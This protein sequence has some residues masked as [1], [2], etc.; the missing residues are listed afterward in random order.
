MF[1][2]RVAGARCTLLNTDEY[3]TMTRTWPI[4]MIRL[5]C[6]RCLPEHA[7]IYSPELVAD[8]NVSPSS[9]YRE[10]LPSVETVAG[11]KFLFC[12]Q[13]L[14]SWPQRPGAARQHALSGDSLRQ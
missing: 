3:V 11:S 12:C 2:K 6:A 4:R 1:E 8:M 9:P 13:P 14:P 5:Q 10:L 7:L